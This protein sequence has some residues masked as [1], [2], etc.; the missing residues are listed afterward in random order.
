[1]DMRALQKCIPSSSSSPSIIIII[2]NIT[3]VID[4]VIIFNAI[5][6]AI[7]AG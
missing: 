3:I 6:R 2:D 1:M 5:I 7:T 4:I